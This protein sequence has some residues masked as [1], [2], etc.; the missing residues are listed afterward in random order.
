MVTR[1]LPTRNMSLL[2][3]TP[4]EP[5]VLNLAQDIHV[6]GELLTGTVELNVA[7]AQERNIESIRVKLCGFGSTY[8]IAHDVFFSP[9]CPTSKIRDS[10]HMQYG[11]SHFHQRFTVIKEEQTIWKVGSAHPDATAHTLRLPFSIQ[12]P[13][14]LPPSFCYAAF[15]RSGRI[16]YS[17]Q[18]IGERRGALQWNVR[19]RRKIPIL[20]AA[21]AAQIQVQRNLSAGW[22]GPWR[23]ISIGEDIRQ[24]IWGAYSRVDAEV[25]H[26]C[27]FCYAALLKNSTDL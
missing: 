22:S 2:D 9:R 10:R 25:R 21:T 6:S 7:L 26:R 8:V 4:T 5:I 16:V 17:I 27:A 20:P 24:G 15:G 13:A 3:N 1:S 23:T 12:L 18:A 19:V 14:E 11:E